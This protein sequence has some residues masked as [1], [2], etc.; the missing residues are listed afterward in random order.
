MPEEGSGIKGLLEFIAHALVDTPGAVVVREVE[1]ELTTVYELE[2]SGDD[3]G[4]VIGKEGR[5][6]RAV[7]TILTAAGMKQHKRI[8]LEIIE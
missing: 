8:V 6:A 3:L 5:T 2:V 1:R 4:K 7:R